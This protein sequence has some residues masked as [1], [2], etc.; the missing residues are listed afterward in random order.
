MNPTI[1]GDLQEAPYNPRKI[2]K[3]QLEVL[4]KSLKEHGDLGAIVF[5]IRT[6]R[7]VGGHQRVKHLDPSWP[8][9]KTAVTEDNG[10]G[11]I[12]VGAILTP[13]GPL[14]YR[15][16]DWSETKEK[17]ANIAAN[18][19]GGDFDIPKLKELLVELDAGDVDLLMTGFDEAELK[20]LIDWD[21]GSAAGADGEVP[22]VGKVAVANLG[23]VYMLDN[24]RVMCGDSTNAIHVKTL[25]DGAPARC[26]WTDPPYGVSYEGK[27]K[28]KLK[29]QNDGAEGLDALLEGAFS[30]ADGEALQDGAAI[31]I[32]HPAGQL[33]LVFD[34]CFVAQGWRLHQTLIWVKDSMVLGHS[35]Y[36]F[37]HEPITFGYKKGEGRLG[38]GGTGWFGPNDC[39]SVFEV[40][41]PKASPDH[42]TSKPVELIEAMLLNSTQREDIVFDPFG[43]SG[44]TLIACE[45]MTRQCRM[46][47]LDPLYVDVIVKRWEQATGKKAVLRTSRNEKKKTKA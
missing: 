22:K 24:H 23:D 45:R 6:G 40:P 38:R 39:T 18:K 32:A 19:I 36:H 15:E 3:D 33:S 7:L 30:A 46:M 14:M 20:K 17:V 28:D 31:Y 21:G 27:T 8:I 2:S 29:I 35:D 13:W 9:Q 44:S 12:A 11:T 34:N 41:R 43:G 42:P 16:V 10:T 26:M 4:G 37:K 1:A 47:E 25:I 5:N